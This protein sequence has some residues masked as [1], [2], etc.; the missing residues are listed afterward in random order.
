MPD[1]SIT[2]NP[3]DTLTTEATQ[4]TAGEQDL[5]RR[6]GELLCEQQY[7]D[8]HI[9]ARI[10][11]RS[12]SDGIAAPWVLEQQ[13]DAAD[14]FDALV[15]LFYLQGSIPADLAGK[16]FPTG[17]LDGLID[18]GLL[19]A[20]PDNSRIHSLV[21]IFSFDEAIF[22]TDPCRVRAV[23]QPEWLRRRLP[24][25]ERVMYL[26][27]D[28]IL[29]AQ[30]TVRRQRHRV[31][32]LCT[33]SGI[34]AILAAQHSD[35]TTGVDIN[36]RALRFSRLNAALNGRPDVCFLE[37]DLYQPTGEGRFDL[38]LANPPFVA[39]PDVRILF[40]DGGDA[41][42]DVLARIVAGLPQRLVEGG[43][44]QIVTD[45]AIRKESSYEQTVR[46]WLGK[47]AEA[48]D[49]L[50][51]VKTRTSLIDYALSHRAFDA[52]SIEP[53]EQS[54]RFS[55]MMEDFQREGLARF[56]FGLI[57]IRRRPAGEQGWYREQS[58]ADTGGEGLGEAIEE[59]FERCCRFS[60]D[61]LPD[62]MTTLRPRLRRDL[63]V[64]QL[65]LLR[66][67]AP[68][69]DGVIRALPAGSHWADLDLMLTPE[70]CRLLGLCNGKQSVARII[71]HF[72]PPG[73]PA[74]AAR[75]FAVANQIRLF[76]EAGVV[77]LDDD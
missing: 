43:I 28:S 30:G 47:G 57:N 59:F 58:L 23:H 65:L 26:G 24:A 56:D 13:F 72:P 10:P 1:R 2:D 41:G 4:L 74:P 9:L 12:D 42:E 39:A 8:R 7:R 15:M 50:L 44:C 40:R 52:E 29:L 17:L 20:A 45:L 11:H 19:A 63:Q 60:D 27:M 34:H 37:G 38:V 76:Y 16:H 5:M 22:I 73:T 62:S 64:S 49:I 18:L 68:P 31:L 21:D 55:V 75:R 69:L 66:P 6:L 51:A 48:W 33:G 46:G 54:R 25:A 36:P 3:G 71:E 70:S 53:A 61:G 67:G 14:T 35:A 77:D 32:D